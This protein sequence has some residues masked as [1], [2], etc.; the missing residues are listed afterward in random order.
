MKTKLIGSKIVNG[1]NAYEI[2]TTY[3]SGKV[4]SVFYDSKTGLKVKESQKIIFGGF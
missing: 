2:E 4:K 1:S 3:P